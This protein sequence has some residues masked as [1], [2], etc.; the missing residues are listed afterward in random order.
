M[1]LP[2]CFPSFLKSYGSPMRSPMDGKRET[3]L[4]ILKRYLTNLLSKTPKDG[5]CRTSQAWICSGDEAAPR[6]I[7][8]CRTL[9]HLLRRCKDLEQDDCANVIQQSQLFLW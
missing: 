9:A 3:S 4:P 5:D 7:G 2:D 8:G 6:K 1:N